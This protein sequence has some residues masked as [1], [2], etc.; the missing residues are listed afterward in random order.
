MKSS[1]I[2]FD[3]TTL[4]I[5]GVFVLLAAVAIWWFFVKEKKSDSEYFEDKEVEAPKASP[6]PQ[7]QRQEGPALVL[8][9]GDHCPHCHDMMPAW[10]EVRKT[11]EGKLE[12]KEL[13]SQ[14]PENANYVPPR[15]VPTVRLYPNGVSD[16]QTF[17]DYSGDRSPQSI[18]NFVVESFQPLKE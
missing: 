11:L 18:V 3:T 7:A 1:M 10:S 5:I 16:K 12:V 6:A 4:I 15:G 8:F 9:Y 17:V 2:K 14:N 13:E